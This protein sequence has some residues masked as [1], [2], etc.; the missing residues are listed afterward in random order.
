MPMAGKK[1]EDPAA[2]SDEWTYQIGP[3]DFPRTVQREKLHTGP[4]GLNIPE[5]ASPETVDDASIARA[6]EAVRAAREQIAADRERLRADAVD[7]GWFAT[8]NGQTVPMN[9]TQALMESAGVRGDLAG[10]TEGISAGGFSQ[11]EQLLR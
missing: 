2:M 8:P 11:F 9:D 4:T 10:M 3:H 7:Q 1:T 5:L 6:A